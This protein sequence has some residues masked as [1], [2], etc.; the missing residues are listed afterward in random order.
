MGVVRF[1]YP[2]ALSDRLFIADIFV[3]FYKRKLYNCYKTLFYLFSHVLRSLICLVKQEN[4]YFKILSLSYWFIFSLFGVPLIVCNFINCPKNINQ[5]L[6][7][8]GEVRNKELCIFC[9]S[10]SNAGYFELLIF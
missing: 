2:G 5:F 6:I 3:Y 8:L 9:I 7:F 4:F 10:F 1:K